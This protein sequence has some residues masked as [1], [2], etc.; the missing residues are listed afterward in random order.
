[1]PELPEVETIRRGLSRALP[2]K[3]LIDFESDWPKAHN[4]SVAVYRRRL[5]GAKIK[6]VDRRGRLLIFNL[7]RDARIMV[8][9]KMT[10]QLVYRNHGHC[11]IGG[12]PIEQSCAELPNKFTH[13]IFSFSDG[14]KLFFNDVRKF[15]WVRLYGQSE[16]G[17]ALRKM[18]LGPEPLGPEFTLQYFQTQMK[19]RPRSK[20]KA[21]IMDNKVVVGVGN[22]YSDEVLFFSRVRPNRLVGSLNE[23]EIK[24]LHDGI[25]LILTAATAA[26]GTTFS[27]YVNSNGEAGAYTKKLKVYGRYGKKCLKCGREVRRLKIGGRTSSYC[28]ECQK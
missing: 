9:L 20:V 19:G 6:S 5:K 23:G 17:Q 21:F 18:K 26:Q 4:R 25:R 1:M 24:K 2:G 16:L 27:N 28:P 15:G 13:A 3:K 7:D 14:S 8:H 10:G 22:I 12:H 11:L